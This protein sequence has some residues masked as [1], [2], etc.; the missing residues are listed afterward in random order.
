MDRIDAQNGDASKITLAALADEWLA[1]QR[2]HCKLS[3]QEGYA[4][5][6]NNHI[7]PQLGQM[8]LADL[9]PL[10][11]KDFLHRLAEGTYARSNKRQANTFQR[12]PRTA[13]KILAPLNAMLEY[14]VQMGYIVYNPALSIKRLPQ[15]KREVQCLTAAEAGELLAACEKEQDRVMLATLLGT[16][17]RRGELLGLQWGDIDW[18][19]CQVKV[20]R[21]FTEEGRVDTPKTHQIRDVALPEWTKEVLVGYY[22]TQGTP[23]PTEWLFPG[24]DGLPVTGTYLYHLVFKPA[25]KRAGI[26]GLSLHGL[27]HSYATILLDAGAD[28]QSVSRLLGHANINTTGAF[29]AHY[30]RDAARQK[31][32]VDSWFGVSPI[33]HQSESDEKSRGKENHG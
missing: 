25:C 14:A 9:R 3:T 6:L 11:V 8:K 17:I 20:R 33:C 31:K 32:D 15:H 30:I 18:I 7:L 19:R 21:A 24:K 23:Q 22:Q 28:V 5:D 1:H 29:Y 16:G 2:Q 13:N 4:R 27:R 26:E 12:S 10:D